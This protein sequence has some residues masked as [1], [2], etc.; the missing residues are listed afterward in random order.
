MP[1]FHVC[2][3]AVRRSEELADRIRALTLSDRQEVG[4][5][6][7]SKN[8]VSLKPGCSEN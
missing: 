7:N 3:E 6:R 2:S 4:R 5:V 8:A 1:D